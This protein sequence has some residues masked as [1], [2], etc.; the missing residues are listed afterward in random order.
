[1]ALISRSE[2]SSQ[3]RLDGPDR[4]TDDGNST[5]VAF[6]LLELLPG[7]IA[8]DES[9]LYTDGA[10][11]ALIPRQFR[12]TFYNST[13]AAHVQIASARLPQIGAVSRDTSG[14]FILGLIPGLGGP[15]NTAAL[16]I[17]AWAA[18]V[19]FP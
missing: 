11:G 3:V 16:F 19:R 6:S 9:R 12:Q 7:N 18:R 10:Q 1:M 4:P 15:F 8:F 2:L 5:G 13:A 17:Q 14:N